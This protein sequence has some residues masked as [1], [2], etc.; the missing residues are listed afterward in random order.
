MSGMSP[1][2]SD[3]E[4]REHVATLAGAA[5][6][7]AAAGWSGTWMAVASLLFGVMFGFIALR[8]EAARSVHPDVRDELGAVAALHQQLDAANARAQSAESRAELERSRTLD[9][10]RRVQ[11]LTERSASPAW[12]AA[13]LANAR[14]ELAA[15]RSRLETMEA[16]GRAERESIASELRTAMAARAELERELAQ[17]R[18]TRT[19][20]EQ[21]LS[22]ERGARVAAEQGALLAAQQC[23]SMMRSAARPSR[24]MSPTNL[25]TPVWSLERMMLEQMRRA[26]PS[27]APDGELPQS[28]ETEPE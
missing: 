22:Q 14:N 24:P 7:V 20:A 28:A 2:D 15:L 26:R 11:T 9:A 19:L 3:R 5:S 18:A 16:Q 21:Q 6:R 12:E 4:T 25:V 27:V 8:K 23:A 1:W 17:E 10:M 13:S